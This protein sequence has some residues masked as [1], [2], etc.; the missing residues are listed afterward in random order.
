MIGAASGCVIELARL[1][2]GAAAA[3]PRRID[4]AGWTVTVAPC[5]AAWLR[6]GEQDVDDPGPTMA[7]HRGEAIVAWLAPGRWLTLGA[8]PAATSGGHWF[9]AAARTLVLRIEGDAKGFVAAMT[10][11]D[12]AL[13]VVGRS[14]PTRLAGLPVVVVPR[15]GDAL[16]LT[17]R[18]REVYWID[19]LTVAAGVGDETMARR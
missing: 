6:V 16:I 4:G 10:G 2:P 17:D 8:G 11:L 5:R 7:R 18:G 13:L 19:W 15:A 3:L 12:A 1:D 14:L 9:D